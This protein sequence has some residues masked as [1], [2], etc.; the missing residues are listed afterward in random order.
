MGQSVAKKGKISKNQ[1]KNKIERKL[2]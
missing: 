2:N 1:R